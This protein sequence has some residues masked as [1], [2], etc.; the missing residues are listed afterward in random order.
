MSCRTGRADERAW[1]SVKDSATILVVEDHQD[2]RDLAVALLERQGYRVLS[3]GHA[4]EAIA[5]AGRHPEIA[6][7]LAD[8]C[9]PAPMSGRALAERL[10]RERP[11]LGI[12]YMSGGDDDGICP[13]TLRKPFKPAEL[14]ARVRDA[15]RMRRAEVDPRGQN[16][17]PP[18]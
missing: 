10:L 8:I 3:A 16:S 4:A 17:A 9:L 12:L 11:D 1:P 7:L 6:V 2:M 5:L 18:G 13:A 14:V 15:L